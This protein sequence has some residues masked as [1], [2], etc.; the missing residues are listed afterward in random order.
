VTSVATALN[1]ARRELLPTEGSGSAG[2]ADRV[3]ALGG[4]LSVE[5][6]AGG[7]TRLRAEIPVG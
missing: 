7:G 6:P 4:R 3:A 5:S 2:S 1:P